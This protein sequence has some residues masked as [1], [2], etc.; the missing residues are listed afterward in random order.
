MT[1]WISKD[2]LGNAIW[3]F[4]IAVVGIILTFL[5]LMGFNSLAIQAERGTPLREAAFARKAGLEPPTQAPV[6]NQRPVLVEAL[7][8]TWKM[9]GAGALLIIILVSLRLWFEKRSYTIKD[10]PVEGYVDPVA[11]GRTVK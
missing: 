1:H 7:V 10:D 5:I 2:S 4:W 9:G 6:T 8:R 3:S 11:A